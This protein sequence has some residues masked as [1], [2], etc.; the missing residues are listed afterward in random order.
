LFSDP[1][2][3]RLI[4]QALVHNTDLRQ[5]AANLQRARYVL[6]EARAG[7]QPSATADAAYQRVRPGAAPGDVGSGAPATSDFFSLGF[8]AS[9]EIDLFGG[10]SRAIE[11]ASADVGSAQAQVDAARVAV[12]AETAR[13]YAQTCSFAA[14]AAVGRETAMLQ[15]RTLELTERLLT[16]GRGTRR[17]VDEAQVLVEQANAQVPIFEAERRA[18][19]YALAVLTGAPPA[20][21]DYAASRCA[22]PLALRGPLPVG[23]GRALLARRP[24]VRA[25]E[26]QLA[27][28]IARIGVATAELYPSISLLGS[29]SLG[30]PNIGGLGKARSFGFSLGPLISWNFPFQAPARARVHQAGAIADQSLAA[31]DAAVLH[32]LQETEQALARLDGTARRETALARA[33]A[34]SESAARFSGV[35]FRSGADSFLQLLDAERERAATRSDLE[36][37]RADL[38]DAQVSLFKALGGGWQEAPPVAARSAAQR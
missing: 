11:A 37:A 32:A 22:A 3:D 17:D 25:A 18:S 1:D 9:Y 31:F 26:R 6:A 21:F 38:V 34:A 12:A 33:A 19:L 29:V 30:A 7:R 8:D 35:R 16:S 24:D 20:Q 27:G 13:T 14:Q 28:D 5:A 36:Q 15:Q 4:E 2:L 23:D 10:I